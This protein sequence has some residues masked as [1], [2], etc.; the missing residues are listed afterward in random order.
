M[1]V[2][3]LVTDIEAIVDSTLPAYKPRNVGRFVV[4]AHPTSSVDRLFP[5]T[6]DVEH[7][8]TIESPDGFPPAPYWQPVCIG[9]LAM[10]ADY[11]PMAFRMFDGGERKMIAAFAS[12]MDEVKP[13]LVGWNS[14]GFDVP[15]I[16]ARCRRW[17][18]PFMW[19]HAKEV[20]NRYGDGAIDLQEYVTNCGASRSWTLDTEARS[21]GLPGKMDVNGHDV[22]DMVAA[23][24]IT[25][26]CAY[27]LCDVAQTA[28]VFLRV[29]LCR[30]TLAIDGYRA[31]AAK[32][33][34][35]C[36]E[37]GGMVADV[38]E[39]A[40]MGRVMLEE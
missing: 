30:G 2:R 33:A 19:P 7:T 40:D 1:A 26:V 15:V 29:R 10:D 22:A 18:V 23:G 35:M 5:A 6:I 24:R 13:V 8:V 3:Y 36:T 4:P 37:Q 12:R 17:G 34:A 16:D 14:R 11:M 25:E 32:L 27:C 39:R 20:R 9:T 31:A 38:I 28:F 21:M